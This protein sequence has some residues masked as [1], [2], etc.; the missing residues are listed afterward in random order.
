MGKILSRR[1]FLGWTGVFCFG[2][3]ILS[4]LCDGNPLKPEIMLNDEEAKKLIEKIL[5]DNKKKYKTLEK[6]VSL[7]LGEK[8]KFYVDYLIKKNDWTNAVVNYVD[9]KKDSNKE[10]S[11]QQILKQYSIPNLYFP[12]S[13][14]KVIT[15]TLNDFINKDF[16][17]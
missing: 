1:T 15:S 12:K 7:S 6:N 16:K 13:S 17:N 9:S 3:G 2:A 11:N 14:E 10:V 4:V 8:D 5:V